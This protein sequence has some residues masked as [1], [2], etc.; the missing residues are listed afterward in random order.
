MTQTMGSPGTPHRRRWLQAALK[1][2]VLLTGLGGA[3][4]AAWA[5]LPSSRPDHD[6]LA[7]GSAGTALPAAP[8]GRSLTPEITSGSIDKEVI[9]RVIR[10]H[11]NEVR[12]CY[13]KGL[14]KNPAL[15]GR[16]AVAFRIGTSGAVESSVVRDSTLKNPEVEACIADRVRRWQFPQP[17][18]GPVGVTYPFVLRAAE[19]GPP[20]AQKPEEGPVNKPSGS[21]SPAASGAWF[22]FSA[23]PGARLLC[24][25]HVRGAGPKPQ[26]IEWRLYASVEPQASVVHHYER[27]SRERAVPEPDRGGVGLS[28]KG[29][30][31]DKMSVFSVENRAKYP[32]CQAAIQPG[33]KTLILVSR[34]TM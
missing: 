20:P 10:M 12:F 34:G 22:S 17:K 13:E 33:E 6:P 24:Q 16:I 29:D 32:G 30:A 19:A 15:E 31:R 5:N 3:S 14:A 8:A 23:F 4:T 9:R 7:G 21:P 2:A 11:M 26:E 25:E 28:A 27:E 1:V 18:G